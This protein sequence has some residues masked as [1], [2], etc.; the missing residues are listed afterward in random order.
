MTVS[1]D[2]NVI[3]TQTFDASSSDAN[4]MRWRGV[5][6]SVMATTGTTR[7]AFASTVGSACGPAVDNVS[8]V[9]VVAPTPTPSPT[10]TPTPSPATT[11]SV[12][13]TGGGAGQPLAVALLIAALGVLFAVLSTRRR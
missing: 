4:D 3:D 10:A 12:P 11:P 2:G 9:A 13:S 7:L 6:L 8:V 1:W 5:A